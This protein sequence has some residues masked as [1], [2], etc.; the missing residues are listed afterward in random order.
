MQ[1]P[2]SKYDFLSSFRVRADISLKTYND[3]L[4][5]K[6]Y[7]RKWGVTVA[8][9]NDPDE[10]KN[11]LYVLLYNKNSATISDND[12][13][14]KLEDAVGEGGSGIRFIQEEVPTIEESDVGNY[15][16]RLSDVKLFARIQFE[17]NEEVYDYW[18]EITSPSGIQN[19]SKDIQNF[20]LELLTKVG[21]DTYIDFVYDEDILIQVDYYVDNTKEKKL[22]TKTLQ[23]DNEKLIKTIVK[24][25]ITKKELHTE[26]FYEDDVLVNVKK[27]IVG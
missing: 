10:E 18:I 15:W 1:A 20:E 24:D 22:F 19:F 13:W 4:A 5:L 16:L 3:L 21:K 7:R 23:Y 9:Y 26:L 8:V 25:E 2:V 6:T 12:N 17:E 11:G 14:D 27:H